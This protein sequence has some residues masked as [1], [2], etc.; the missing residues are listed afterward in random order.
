MR[1]SYQKINTSLWK[2]IS[3]LERQGNGSPSPS[4]TF[5]EGICLLQREW[6]T[7]LMRLAAGMAHC[8]DCW[9]GDGHKLWIK[10][11]WCC[12]LLLR[13]CAG[14]LAGEITFH[15]T[16]ELTLE[17]IFGLTFEECRPSQSKPVMQDKKFSVWSRIHVIF[18]PVQTTILRLYVFHYR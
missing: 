7:V 11:V 18:N 10:L 15:V 16:Q 4:L 8:A 5:W 14:R 12:R 6:L 9:R 13:W 2:I 3:P 17:P 1:G